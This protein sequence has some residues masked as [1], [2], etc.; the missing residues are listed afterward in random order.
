MKGSEKILF[1]INDLP[2]FISHRLPLARAARD[3]GY[4]VCVAAPSS[5]SGLLAE[6]FDFFELPLSRGGKAFG[7]E[8]GTLVSIYKVMKLLKPDLVHLV[9]IKPVLYGGIAARLA[10]VPAVVSAVSGLGAVFIAQGFVASCLRFAVNRLYRLALG[11]PNSSVIFQNP[12]DKQQFV[13]A[14]LVAEEKTCLIRGSGVDLDKYPYVPEPEGQCVVTMVSRLLTDKGVCEFVEA[15]R[16]LRE[17][18]IEVSMRIIGDLDPANPAAVT[19]QQLD[20]WKRVG[21]VE[22]C[23]FRSDIAHQYA[24]SNVAC[25]PSYREGL[26]KSLV[27]AA[28][29]GRAVITTDV[30]GCRYALDPGKTGLLVPVRDATALADAIE[31]LVKNPDKRKGLGKAGRELAEREFGIRGVVD[32][33]MQLYRTLLAKI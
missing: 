18:E 2:F 33:H 1:V 22:F 21:D 25:L 14:G 7:T 10:K 30:P 11:H 9:T 23:G 5:Q 29:C 3:L 16:I 17:R 6:E 15:A 24:I 12:D 26:P 20:D 4:T 13:N 8:F 19:Q 31:Y 27:E 32:A 28:A